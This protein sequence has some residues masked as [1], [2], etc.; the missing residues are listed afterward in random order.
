VR[1][2][3]E[4]LAGYPGLVRRAGTLLSTALAGAVLA[5]CSGPTARPEPPAPSPATSSLLPLSCSDSAGQQGQDDETV[6][7]GVEGLILPGSEDPA[8]LYPI[9]TAGSGQRYFMYKAF[10]A[11]AASAA[12]YATVSVTRP[13]SARLVYAAPSRIGALFSARSGRGLLS[14]SRSTIRLPVCGPRYTGFTGGVIVTGPACVTFTVS[15]PAARA[16]T[17]T[18]P[19]G[20][21]TC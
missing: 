2:G 5:A 15:S 9:G 18:V 16:A 8:G 1:V 14:A 6:I 3:R 13:A 19:I 20:P 4:G 10:L 7:G 11:V 12:P 17:V 21:V